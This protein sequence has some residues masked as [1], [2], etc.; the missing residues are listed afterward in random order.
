VYA[1]VT[2][3]QEHY[4][5]QLD[6]YERM[7]EKIAAPLIELNM[8]EKVEIQKKNFDYGMTSIR[9]APVPPVTQ[10]TPGQAQDWAQQAAER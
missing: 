5:Q 3:D 2:I 6:F 8:D 4:N 10:V 7:A 1:G 9:P